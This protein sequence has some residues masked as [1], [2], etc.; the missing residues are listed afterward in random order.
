[1]VPQSYIHL[2]VLTIG[3]SSGEGTSHT[4]TTKE[5]VPP[6]TQTSTPAYVPT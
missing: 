5:Q 3:M 2:I 1:M 6:V 4:E